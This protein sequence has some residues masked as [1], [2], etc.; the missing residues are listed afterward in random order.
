MA[1]LH[2]LLLWFLLRF[3]QGDLSC[4]VLDDLERL[5]DYVRVGPRFSTPVLQALFALLK[6]PP[7]KENSRLLVIGTA[8]D[9]S[10][11]E[12]LELLQAFNVSLPVPELTE[13]AH[14]KQVLETLPGFTPPAVQEISAGL[15]GQRVG[16][17][18]LLL[19][20]EM[21]VQRQNPVQIEAFK[22]CMRQCG[23]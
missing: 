13:P 14:Y 22:E 5:I 8:T 1:C 12:E 4:I 23:V 6:R 7:P 19:V 20:S 17:K 3:L 9:A 11:L 10:C 15:A 21:A 16:I 2:L 18:T